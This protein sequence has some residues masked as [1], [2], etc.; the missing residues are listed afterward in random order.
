M[1]SPSIATAKLNTIVSRLT[2]A[3]GH[4]SVAQHRLEAIDG[5]HGRRVDPVE[6]REVHAYKVTEQQ[7]GEHPLE[8]TLAMCGD[9][10]RARSHALDLRT[11]Q[12]DVAPDARVLVGVLEE[13]RGK[14]SRS[15]A[16]LPA[17]DLVVV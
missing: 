14:R 16:T 15:G 17:A 2:P 7:L 5:F 9:D 3:R 13:D 1:V 6:G 11:Q 4:G 8:A 10:E 12:L